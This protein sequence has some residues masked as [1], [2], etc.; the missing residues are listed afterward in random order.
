MKVQLICNEDNRENLTSELKS[1]GFEVVDKADY[2][3]VDKSYTNKKY[4]FAK[5]SKKNISLVEYD[6]IIYFE[7]F[8]KITEVV[9]DM[10]RFEVKEK[11]YELEQML[12]L[13]DFVRINKS[14]II[15]LLKVDKIIPWIGSKFVLDMKDGTRVE[16]TRSY[17][18]AFKKRLGL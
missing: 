5:D 4:I 17:F 3:F 12:S 14:M 7:S 15:N 11:L 13:Q 1:K 2:L 8:N 18:S 9:T 16:V 6:N 10:G